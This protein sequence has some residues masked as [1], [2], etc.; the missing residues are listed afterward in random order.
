MNHASEVVPS[1]RPQSS[2]VYY[3]PTFAEGY[4][5]PG[6]GGTGE[7]VD[8]LAIAR[9][10]WRKKFVILAIVGVLTG[11]TAALVFLLPRHYVAHALVVVSNANDAAWSTADGKNAP[12]E[13]LPD[14]ETVQTEVQILQSPMLAAEVVRDL[15]LENR[16]EFN[17]AVAKPHASL[18]TAASQFT[19]TVNKF[20][21]R[22][23]IDT[24][25]KSRV[26]DVGFDSESP[27]VAA[28]AVNTLVDEYMANQQTMLTRAA[29]QQ[30][31]WLQ[32]RIDKLQDQTAKDE[33]AIAEYRAQAGLYTVPGG[34]PLLLQ[35]M[36]ETSNDLTKA[37]AERTVLD[38]RL[39]QLNTS[40]SLTTDSSTSDLLSSRVMTNLRTQEANLEEQLA[41]SSQEYGPSYPATRDLRAQLAA[42]KAQMR[43]EAQQITAA[44]K[45]DAE[46]AR[47]REQRL[48]DRLKTLQQGVT[49]MNAADVKL[50]ALQRQAEADRLVLNNYLAR[51][52]EV[53]QDV[54]K[55]AQRPGSA[56]VSYAQVPVKPDKPRR[57]LLIA[58]AAAISLV[59]G[60]GFVLFR[61]KSDR[62]FRSLEELE[63]M[64]GITSLGLIPKIQAVTGSPIGLTRYDSGSPYREAVKAI[65]TGLFVVPAKK[66]KT[67]LITSAYPSE[68]KT[69]LALS[70]AILA[71]QAGQRTI[72]VDA[73]FWRA[74]ASKALGRQQHT[75]GLAE[76][77]NG[78]ASLEDALISDDASGI[79]LLLPGKF[80]RTSG[81]ARVENLTELLGVLS[82]RYDFIII[83]SPPVFAV[84]EALV[85]ASHAD[86][87]I[88][89]VRWGKTPRVAVKFALKRLREVGANVVG[90]AL[91]L[92]DQREHAQY[93]FGES[94]YFSKAIVGYYS[95][96][97]A[98]SWSSGSGQQNKQESSSI[99]RRLAARII[100]LETHNGLATGP[101]TAARRMV[102][103]QKV[104]P[105]PQYDQPRQ[106]LLV[107]D[108][109]Q[110]F[111]TSGGLLSIPTAA[112]GQLVQA[113][114]G[115]TRKA[116]DSGLFVAY[117]QQQL[118]S[119][120]A[121]IAARLFLRDKQIKLDDRLDPRVSLVSGN[122][123]LKPLADA[124]SSGK[125]DAFLRSRQVNHLFLMGIGG[126]TSVALTARSALNR[127][128]SVTFINDGI[129][130]TSE[131]KWARMLKEFAAAQAFAIT[132]RDFHELFKARVS[133]SGNGN[134]VVPRRSRKSPSADRGPRV[135]LTDSPIDQPSGI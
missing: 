53:G 133:P 135:V 100:R 74:A 43:I 94:A 9:H 34:S 119:G 117:T 24:R 114:N 108:V 70:L 15:K 23:Q 36:A 77:L 46:L 118:D 2:A 35:Q 5:A 58:I 40:L 129:F 112:V 123:F 54:D 96:S 73:D 51:Y 13:I 68:G 92:V 67:T 121:K 12:V 56:I 104:V 32:D 65:Y 84:S 130:T 55:A 79:D 106:A 62:T 49:K 110:A 10:L 29:K 91:T 22:L 85:L 20:L 38:D 4:F 86:E 16:V 87:T 98:I 124:F 14:A 64:T 25:G 102:L 116:R 60:C 39:R 63:S 109:Q 27:T 97:D 59:G 21:K 125:L 99:R 45:N 42:L 69:T 11:A 3:A 93:G 132:S 57:A 126:A 75:P 90:T 101:W 66:S 31:Q 131:K 37:E 122:V 113:V 111:T 88:V 41:L 26:I 105:I 18:P 47:M 7:D 127:G 95:R 1:P 76:V 61:N 52:K 83:D 17:P 30:S 80:S 6:S 44:V 103:P 78:N 81:L 128:Y 120:L 50:A 72:V 19:E 8:Y 71:A 82:T 33:Q 28:K 134:L 115:V 89:A 48:A 107:I